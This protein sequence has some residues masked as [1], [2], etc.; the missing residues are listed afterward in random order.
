MEKIESKINELIEIVDLASQPIQ[1]QYVWL[2]DQTTIDNYNVIQFRV[3]SWNTF[4]PS[5]F[6]LEDANTCYELGVMLTKILQEHK[7]GAIAISEIQVIDS[8]HFQ[9]S[10]YKVAYRYVK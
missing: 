10:E 1:E 5:C 6:D 7:D 4:P 2:T 9:I 3:C 8:P